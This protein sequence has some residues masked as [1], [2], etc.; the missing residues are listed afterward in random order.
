MSACVSSPVPEALLR[1]QAEKEYQAKL[2]ELA[3]KGLARPED[4]EEQLTEDA[5]EA[6]ISAE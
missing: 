2:L 4:I 5:L 1:A 6:F 3:Q